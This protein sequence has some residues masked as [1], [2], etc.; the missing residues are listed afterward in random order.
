MKNINSKHHFA[1]HDI[2]QFIGLQLRYGV[3]IASLTVLIGGV[4]YL[5][6]TGS[7]GLPDYT[8]FIGEKA[9]F[10]TGKELWQGVLNLN[11]KGIIEFGVVI[12]IATPILRIFF[13][14]IG[15]II[16]KDRMYI[17][18]TLIVLS[19]MLFS[20]FGGLKV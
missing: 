2:E 18:I 4:L 8:H 7:Q 1:D 14:L 9:G 5:I 19:V 16:E 6:N 17:A 3:V 11:P 10:T 13:S 20:V 15:F 12:L